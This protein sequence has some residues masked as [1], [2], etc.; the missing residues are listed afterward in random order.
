MHPLKWKRPTREEVRQGQFWR[1]AGLMLS[2][3]SGV[4]DWPARTIARRCGCRYATTEF[5][6]AEGLS[7]VDPK[8]LGILDNCENEEGLGIQIFGKNPGAMAAAARVVLD[9]YNPDVL[10]INLGCPAP[11]VCRGGGGVALMREPGA[12]RETF[13]ALREAVE[14]PLTCKVRSGWDGGCINAVEI[15]CLAEECGIDAVAVHP[16]TREQM[17]RGP[18][19]WTVT[20]AV[21]QAV[22][23]PVIGNGDVQGWDDYDRM[24]EETGCDG[25]SVGR[26]SIGNPWLFAPRE[27]APPTLQERAGI[28][29]EH[30]RLMVEQ[31]GEYRGI[32]EMR[33]HLACYFR[34]IPGVRAWRSKVMLLESH[35]EVAAALEEILSGPFDEEEAA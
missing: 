14:G 1:D 7:R 30:L 12:L 27:S 15:A 19:D 33:K 32:R 11:K 35:A 4:T 20:R 21:K 23:I 25:V 16:R 26:A 2:P 18:A 22:S 13:Q 17:Y 9:R 29:A 24:I 28:A 10:D 6:S 5:V 3:M 8:S 31:K 34:A